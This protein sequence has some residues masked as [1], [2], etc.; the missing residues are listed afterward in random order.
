MYAI[1]EKEE[2]RIIGLMSG[3]S[4]DG[5]DIALCRFRGHG[6]DTKVCLEK[7]ETV[8]Y[9]PDFKEEIR[10]VFAKPQVDFQKLCML[11][12]WL[13]KQHGLMVLDRLKS[14]DI[15]PASV[16]L[17]AS[18]G[19]T[20][21]HAP[22]W[23]HRDP[24]FGHSTL[25]IGDTDQIAVTTGIISLGDFR[26]KHIAAG[27][28]GAPLAVYGDY[29]LYRSEHENRV[30]L[31]IG[32][33]ANYTLLPAGCNVRTVY[34]TDVGPGNTLIDAAVQRLFNRPFDPDGSIARQGQIDESLLSALQAH[35][36]FKEPLPKTTGP[37]LF[38][39]GYVEHILEQTGIKTLSP[40][41]LVASLT[42][43][44]ASCITTALKQLQEEYG[45]LIIYLSGGGIHNPFLVGR[46]MDAL[47]A[48]KFDTTQ[49]LGIN[50][51]AKEAVLFAVLAN[52]AVAGKEKVFEGNR[53][54]IPAMSMGKISFP[55]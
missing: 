3:T 50:P 44:S 28:E 12:P 42:A 7:F 15:P 4:L 36:F 30:L 41:G 51:D 17:I 29:L 43:F 22:R 25:Q 34:A 52:E 19:Q 9:E 26:Q 33:I 1:A 39:V 55:Q 47:P 5:L 11:H 6:L 2:R 27:G 8:S 20:V 10:A 45:D 14:W 48:C 23:M 21:F 32:G 35:P 31:N 16:D 54:G 38:N 18:H 24:R 49:S 37:E 13:G 46:V 53:C 40:A